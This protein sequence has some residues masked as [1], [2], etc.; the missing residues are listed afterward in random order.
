MFIKQLSHQLK[1]PIGIDWCGMKVSSAISLILVPLIV[2]ILNRNQKYDNGPRLTTADRVQ[3]AGYHCETH[4]VY[5]KDGYGLS[6][7]HITTSNNE[8]V[9]ESNGRPTILLMHGFTSSSDVWVIE[10]L[11][12]PLVYDLM[13][14]GY[15]V[16][17]GNNRGNYYGLRHLNLSPDDGQFWHFTL[18]EIGTID[19]PTIIDFIL[20]KTQKSC[21]HY[22]GY[23]QGSTVAFILL[24]EL[25][26]YGEKLKSI[27][28]LAPTLSVEPS[29]LFFKLL[30]SIIGIHTPLHAYMGDM[31]VMRSKF[32]RQFLGLERCRSQYA[33]K[34]ICFFMASLIA[35]GKSDYLD[36]ALLPDIFNTHPCTISMHQLLH[37]MQLNF[38]RQFRQY[39]WGTEGNMKRYNQT[40]PPVYDLSKIQTKLPI[41]LFYSDYDEIA[42]KRNFEILSQLLGNRSIS[43]SADGKKF[44]HMDFVWSS[45]IRELINRP[46]IEI[47][48]N[49][50]ISLEEH[51]QI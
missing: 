51:K 10:G 19:L 43:H 5:T 47:I 44:A 35:G 22:V 25:P 49:A 15:D 13:Q 31:G 24:S 30:S 34:K 27:Q 50:E 33:N 3:R 38:S 36:E 1:Y 45:V 32:M 6:L 16:W 7:F 37:F 39:N 2:F 48:Q 12:N 42:T 46:V 8:T 21:L 9:P 28:M 23:S 4:E 18:H 40:T 11:K 29:N 17:L 14:Q 20:N 41:H 26:E